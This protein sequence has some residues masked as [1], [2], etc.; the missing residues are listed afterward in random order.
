M[1]I[2]IGNQARRKFGIG[3]GRDYGFG[4][5]ALIATPH[6]IYF[7]RGPRP[8]A[9]DDGITFFA[10]V[11]GGADSALEIFL[12]PR[13]GVQRFAFWCGDFDD[14]VVKTGNGHAEILVVQFGE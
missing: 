13:Q 9:L 5:F 14:A 2:L 1:R 6:T 4:A 11:C 3:L 12:F 8:Q 10:V 7:Q